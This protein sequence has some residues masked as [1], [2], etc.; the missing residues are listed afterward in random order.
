MN[1]DT[2]P[3][4]P[5]ARPVLWVLVIYD[6]LRPPDTGPAIEIRGDTFAEV[7]AYLVDTV[8]GWGELTVTEAAD[9]PDKDDGM[10]FGYILRDPS[11]NHAGTATI[12][13]EQDR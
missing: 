12:R 7:H 1:D 13:R 6:D 5:G 10:R 11:G 3:D 9:E 8:Y 2:E 4:H